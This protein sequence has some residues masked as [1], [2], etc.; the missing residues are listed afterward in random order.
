MVNI[1]LFQGLHAIEFG[2]PSQIYDTLGVY[3]VLTG[4]DGINFTTNPVFT[5][6]QPMG[7]YNYQTGRSGRF[8]WCD[9]TDLAIF[10][11]SSYDLALSSDNLEHIANPI[12]ALVE[13]RRVIKPNGYIFLV[14]PRKESNFDHQ[15]PHTSFEHILSDYTNNVDEHDLTHLDEILRLH[16]LE[17][18]PW[19]KP[20][21]HFEQRSKDNFNNRCL[22]HHVFNTKLIQCIFDYMDFETVGIN[23]THSNYFALARVKK[24]A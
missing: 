20:Y 2:G 22:H 8:W 21:E 24:N 6:G 13:W 3:S 17:R 19:A 14:L 12:R 16:D 5:Q 1:E 23:N 9:A 18:D 11:D 4:C 7:A 15:R 10:S